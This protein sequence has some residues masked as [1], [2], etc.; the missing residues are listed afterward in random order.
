MCGQLSQSGIQVY[1]IPFESILEAYYDSIEKKRSNPQCIEF[2]LNAPTELSRLHRDLCDGTYKPSMSDCFIVDRP[3]TREI[4]ASAFRDRIVHHWIKLRLNPLYEEWYHECG[5]VSKNCRAGHGPH[6]AVDDLSEMIQ[7]ESKNYTRDCWVLSWDIYGCFMSIDKSILWEMMRQ[8]IQDRY[9]GNDE[10]FLL[11]LVKVTAFHSPQRYCRFLSP[12]SAWNNLPPNKSLR[13][14]DENIGIAPGNLSSQDEANFYLTPLD[15][16]IVKVKGFTKYIRFM[17]DGRIVSHDLKGLQKLKDE[18]DKFLKEQL[19]LR[20]HPRKVH[21]DHYSKGVKFV[22][23]VIKP[24]RIYTSNRIIGH[25]YDTIYRYNQIVERGYGE[26]YAEKFV[27][28]LN[29]YWGIMRHADSYKRRAKSASWISPKW[30]KYI[31]IAAGHHKVV[32]RSRYKP[33]NKARKMIK[34]RAHGAFFTPE[35]FE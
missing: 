2:S 4:I 30:Y 10:E 12:Q 5:N 19:R 24:G 13:N 21:I 32:L 28:S 15:Y 17:D 18:I 33:N 20:L 3:V 6:S 31:Y 7:Q 29:S 8:F 27:A 9:T 22:G 11:W 23:A 35:M 16:Y 34:Q 14:N 1:D 26:Q 25:L